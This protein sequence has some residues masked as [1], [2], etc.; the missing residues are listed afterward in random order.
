MDKSGRGAH[1]TGVVHL[2]QHGPG[3]LAGDQIILGLQ[4]QEAV[5]R[6]ILGPQALPVPHQLSAEGLQHTMHSVRAGAGSFGA[7]N[8]Q[9]PRTEETDYNIT[10]ASRFHVRALHTESSDVYSQG[11]RLLSQ[12]MIPRRLSA[13]DE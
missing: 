9:K 7:D 8:T 4:D 6:Q 10:I 5:L 3:E 2:V 12:N 1:V 11:P 13:C